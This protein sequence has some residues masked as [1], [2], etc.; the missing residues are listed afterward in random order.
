[1]IKF[2]TTVSFAAAVAASLISVP[3]LAENVVAT[4]S[5]SYAGL[6]LSSA[7]GQ[8]TMHSRIRSAARTVCGYEPG[9]R[10]LGEASRQRACIVTAMNG[11]QVQL[12]AATDRSNSTQRV[13]VSDSADRNVP[14]RAH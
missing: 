3:A 4:K 1:M 7:A 6:D 12:A 9:E 13:A 2:V 5:V 14:G 11:A 8:A 10:N